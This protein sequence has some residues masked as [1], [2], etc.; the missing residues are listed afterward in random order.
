MCASIQDERNATLKRHNN[1]STLK[2]IVLS[3]LTS[4]LIAPAFANAQTA[5]G[6]EVTGWIPYWRAATGTIDTLPHLDVLTEVNPFVFSLK[7]DGTL[8]DNGTATDEA[9]WNAFNAQAKA[10]GV[11]VI[12]TVMSGDRDTMHTVLSTPALR[13]TLVNNISTLVKE[14]GYDGID[15]DFEFKRAETKDFFSAFLQELKASLGSEKWLMCTIETRIPIADKYF[16][17]TT[18]PV[19]AEVFSNDLKAINQSCDRVRLMAYD[20]QGIDRKLNAEVEAT[21][22]LHAPVAD[23][24]WVEKVVAH[25]SADISKNKMLIGI[26]TYGYEYAVTTYA[27]NQHVYD[28]MWTFNPGYAWPVA[29]QRGIVPLRNSAGEMY[30]TYFGSLPTTTPPISQNVL[31]NLAAA[32]AS[33]YANQNNSNLTY[34]LVTWPDAESAKQKIELAKRLGVRGVSF[35]K[36]DGGQDPAIWNMLAGVKVADASTPSA[37][38]TAT[39]P[40]TPT[41][42]ATAASSFKRSLKL[43]SVGTDVKT[44][45][46]ILNKSTDTK[47]STS[48]AGAPG[49]ETNKFG[50]LTLRALQ[51][52]QVKHGIAKPGV[53]GYGTVGPKTRAKL[54]SLL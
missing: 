5:T 46:V 14:R 24:R 22:E 49:Q 39:T 4:L 50:S 3:A 6:F 7:S 35:F 54:N 1:M 9:L 8:F 17:V 13:A 15:I 28:I 25:M 23:P 47:V 53:A 36:F 45:Q 31:A 11:R 2:Y 42:P 18:I 19:D 32:A 40:T 37:P 21:G 34:R 38:V 26:P 12:P 10:K 48:G 30:F 44:L 41:T 33:T 29:Q 52:F 16:G 43:G 20:Q 27:G 51:K